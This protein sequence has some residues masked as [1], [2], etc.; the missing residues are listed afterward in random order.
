MSFVTVVAHKGT[1]QKTETRNYSIC[2]IEARKNH[3]DVG[4]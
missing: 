4:K 3:S 2:E 1:V